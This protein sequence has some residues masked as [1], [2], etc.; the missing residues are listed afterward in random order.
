MNTSFTS[1]FFI[2]IVTGIILSV[3][4]YT[5]QIAISQNFIPNAICTVPAN[6]PSKLQEIFN[7]ATKNIPCELLQSLER[8]EIFE[9][10]AKN[11]PRA[12]A[13]ARIL[14]VRKDAISD[15]EIV[16]V[17]IHELGH[18]IDLGGLT[19]TDFQNIS[20]F[21]DGALEFYEDDLSLLFYKISWTPRSVKADSQTLDFVSGYAKYDMFEDF[22]E[23]FVLYINHGKYF[24]AL[25][26]ENKKL[27]NK[28]VF[29]KY[30]VF[31]GKEFNT[32]SI[33]E[34]L[35]VRNWDITRL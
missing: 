19:G 10:E 25:A 24:K 30:Y 6:I 28:Y 15:P 2:S 3:N 9:N 29:F 26:L 7:E 18:V 35:F 4:S 20:D 32:G 22:A 27:R 13:N 23:S 16:S 34:N 31:K 21:H 17:I 33:P 1:R 8:V 11:M 14:K 5:A 12:M